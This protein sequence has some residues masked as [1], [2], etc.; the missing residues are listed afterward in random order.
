MMY[1]LG[2]IKSVERVTSSCEPHYKAIVLTQM[3]DS[4]DCRVEPVLLSLYEPDTA[5]E[6]FVNRFIA[7]E[8]SNEHSIQ[9]A[10]K[11]AFESAFVEYKN[12]LEKQ[13]TIKG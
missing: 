1:L 4:S 11:I 12:K 2:Y 10:V 7:I 3:I 13:F 5:I 8:N 9:N 6:E